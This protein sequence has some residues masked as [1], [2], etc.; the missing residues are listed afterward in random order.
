MVVHT[1]NRC[2]KDFP[3]LAKLRI[4]LEQKNLCKPS[5]TQ[6]PIVAPTPLL[7]NSAID[8]IL[9][10]NHVPVDNLI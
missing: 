5:N 10:Q 4:H 9:I 2:R 6:N 3:K 1:C 7:Q 8:Q